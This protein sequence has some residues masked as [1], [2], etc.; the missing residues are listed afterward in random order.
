MKSV[1]VALLTII[2]LSSTSSTVSA[3]ASS[4]WTIQSIDTMKYSRDLS[5]QILDNPDAFQSV[6]DIQVKD[7]AKAGATHVAIATPYDEKY[8]PV[9]KMWVASAR[10]NNLKVWFRGNFSGWEGWFGFPAIDRETH[11]RMLTDFLASHSELFES[12]DLF[13]S[14]P[15]CENGG[16]GDPRQTG[17]TEGHRKFLIDEYSIA[18]NAF[19]LMGKN[20]TP[21]LMSM[22]GDVARVI[23]DEETTQKLGGYVVIDHYVRTPEKMISDIREIAKQSK[24]K[25]ILGELGAP[26]PDLQ[27]EMT[28]REQQKWL[29]QTLSSLAMEKSVVGINY[30]VGFGGST[31]LWN[32]GGSPRLAVETL[33]RYFVPPAATGIVRGRDNSPLSGVTVKTPWQATTTKSDGTFVL[34]LSANDDE[35][36][37]FA[38]GYHAQKV[39]VSSL[40]TADMDVRLEKEQYSLFERFKLFLLRIFG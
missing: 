14:C 24:G 4:W 9:L 23:M 5:G 29:D 20:V 38:T 11:K 34:P 37:F 26:I 7:I 12:G 40:G 15:E 28:E 30:W 21:N 39:T 35:V 22:N 33:Y 16:P 17:D 27:G 1:A 32:D 36:S 31:Q 19:F 25:I 18:K 2:L 6:I 8:I 13:S 10:A 3:L